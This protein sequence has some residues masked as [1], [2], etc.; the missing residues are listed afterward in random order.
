ME[1]FDFI[2]KQDNL[3]FSKLSKK[4]LEEIIYYLNLYLLEYRK[5]LNLESKDTFGIEIETEDIIDYNDIFSAFAIYEDEGWTK[6]EDSSLDDGLEFTSPAL[7]DDKDS[8][9]AIKRVCNILKNYSSINDKCAAHVHVGAQILPNNWE[10]FSRFLLLWATY[11]DVIYRFCDGEYSI[12]RSGINDYALQCNFDFNEYYNLLSVRKE[13]IFLQVFNE[14]RKMDNNAVSFEKCSLLGVYKF[15]NT[16]E[17]RNPN[18]TLNPVIWQNNINLFIKMLYYV[19]SDRF[20]Y[21]I[22]LNRRRI[23]TKNY[24]YFSNY[25]MIHLDNALEFCDL[26]FNNNLDKVYFLKQYLKNN[27]EDTKDFKK[28]LGLTR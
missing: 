6:K 4:D 17:F 21:D 27:N 7:S 15:N 2:N 12:T 3:L 19:T 25:N 5:T 8:W 16:I 28:V 23:N 14:L 1:I 9:L 20:N 11:E 18:G 22:I 26:I 24:L 10:I 13:S